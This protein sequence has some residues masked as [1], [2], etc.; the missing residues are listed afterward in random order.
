MS[1]REPSRGGVAHGQH[2]PR[3][4]FGLEG[5]R[6]WVQALTIPRVESLYVGLGVLVHG[7][8]Y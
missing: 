1:C 4:L 2:K 8:E 7:F 6:F 3:S 5:F